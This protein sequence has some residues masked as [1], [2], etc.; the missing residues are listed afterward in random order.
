VVGPLPSSLVSTDGAVVISAALVALDCP[1][2]SL[3]LSGSG[4]LTFSGGL[5]CLF[6]YP[7]EIAPL[8]GISGD[9]LKSFAGI[10]LGKQQ[11]ALI[12]TYL[13]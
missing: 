12:F 10:E 4:L 13:T 5:N 6:L 8:G 2:G 3:V 1:V 11:V 7:K 9:R